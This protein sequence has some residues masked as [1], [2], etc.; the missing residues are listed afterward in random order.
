MSYLSTAPLGMSLVAFF[1][2]GSGHLSCPDVWMA[3]R[4]VAGV[5]CTSSWSGSRQMRSWFAADKM[6]PKVWGAPSRLSGPAQT[7]IHH[8]REHKEKKREDVQLCY[9]RG[10]PTIERRRVA[11]NCPYVSN[12]LPMCIGLG[13][14]C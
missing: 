9:S 4:V 13:H 5:P 1:Q 10:L 8:S 12:V 11:C 14:P 2:F 3:T 7:W 6:T